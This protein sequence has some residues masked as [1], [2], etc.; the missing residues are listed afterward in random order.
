MTDRQKQMLAA[1]KRYDLGLAEL[2]RR[3]VEAV[4]ALSKRIAQK[5]IIEIQAKYGGKKPGAGTSKAAR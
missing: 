4:D 5:K 1:A 3:Q 2:R